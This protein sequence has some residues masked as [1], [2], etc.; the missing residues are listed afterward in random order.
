MLILEHIEGR[1]ESYLRG[2]LGAFGTRAT[3][4]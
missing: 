1:C 2:C 4:A 3:V